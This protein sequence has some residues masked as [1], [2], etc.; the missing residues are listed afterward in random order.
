MLIAISRTFSAASH[1]AEC[2]DL[3]QDI[4]RSEWGYEGIVMTD[5]IIAAMM[6]KNNKYPGPQAKKIAAAGGD[7]VMPGGKGDYNSILQGLK[8]GTLSRRQLEVNAT[9][10]YRLSKRLEENFTKNL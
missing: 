4:L 5:W 10:V 7:L 8:D 1:T 6:G 2:R 3:I 9:R